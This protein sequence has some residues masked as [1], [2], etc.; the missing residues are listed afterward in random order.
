MILDGLTF[1]V[2][3]IVLRSVRQL[4]AHRALLADRGSNQG[5]A[6]QGKLQLS[7]ISP[8]GAEK[9]VFEGHRGCGLVDLLV[10]LLV[11]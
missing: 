3:S 1:A 7:S 6:H 2:E 5:A 9:G 8:R 11:T 4:R 10:R